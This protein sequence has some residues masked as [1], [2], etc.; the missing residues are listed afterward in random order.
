MRV[1]S[2]SPGLT[3][4]SERGILGTRITSATTTLPATTTALPG[5]SVPAAPAEMRRATAEAGKTA[6]KGPAP[7]SKLTV[8]STPMVRPS[9]TTETTGLPS[10]RVAEVAEVTTIMMTGINTTKSP[11]AR[12]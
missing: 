5:P 6:K 11:G 2:T 10:Y 1:Q 12:S 8:E 7:S 4:A 3:V 9:T